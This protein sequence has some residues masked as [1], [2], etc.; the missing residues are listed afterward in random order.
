MNEFFNASTNN[1]RKREIGIHLIFKDPVLA[2]MHCV[3]CSWKTIETWFNEI[4]TMLAQ[5][6]YVLK[7]AWHQLL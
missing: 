1:H 2:R 4:T 7:T 3:L 6:A 5:G